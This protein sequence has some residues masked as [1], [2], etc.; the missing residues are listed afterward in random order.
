VYPRLP[1]P[2]IPVS[3]GSSAGPAVSRG[4]KGTPMTSV[5]VSYRRTDAPAHAGRLFDRLVDR[6]GQASVFKDLDSME[7]GADFEEVIEETVARCD[8]LIAVIGRDWLAAERGGAR[9]LDDPEDLVRLEVANALKRRI[10]VVPVLVAGASMPSAAELPEDLQPLA[11]RH[12]VELSETAWGAQVNQLID[13]L[14]RAFTRAA[15]DVDVPAPHHAAV[16]ANAM[17]DLVA[18]EVHE[19]FNANRH[20]AF[21]VIASRAETGDYLQWVGT[22]DDGFR[23]EI[24]DPGRNEIPPRPL[25]RDQLASVERLGFSEEPV[26]FVRIFEFDEESLPHIVEVIT[27]AF[28]DV[29]GLTEAHQV[30]VSTD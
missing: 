28:A 9:R 21:R 18:E 4:P 8:A 27:A 11:R 7:P 16:T 25:T 12:A 10:R 1:A 17:Q 26:N 29:F 3:V 20:G 23:V 24:S 13:A 15:T 5:F 6:F 22:S 30:E 14:E 2:A 19:I